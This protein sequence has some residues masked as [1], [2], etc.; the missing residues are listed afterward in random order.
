M[1]G[2]WAAKLKVRG[3]GGLL[4]RGPVHGLLNVMA[5]GQSDFFHGGSML[6]L[7]VSAGT[8]VEAPRPFVT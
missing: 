7:L 5:S 2:A 3:K 6:Q 8:E 4:T 1:S